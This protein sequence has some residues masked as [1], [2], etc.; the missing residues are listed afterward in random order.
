MPII[1]TDGDIARLVGEE[2][3]APANLRAKLVKLR[4]VRGHSEGK[5]DI[6]GSGGSAFRV[7]VRQ[8]DTNPLSFSVIL[9]YL[10][11]GSNVWFRLR[12]FNGSNHEHTNK[13]EESKVSFTNHI[14][15]ATERYQ[16]LGMK[17]DAYAEADP[18]FYDL[19]GAVDALIADCGFKLPQPPSQPQ[20]QPELQLFSEALDG[21]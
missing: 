9:A 13:I 11:P 19:E 1:L 16:N 8:S 21:S 7:I 3:I 14:H 4:A 2:K 10:P 6:T 18:R 17:E 20:S 5:F 15:Y 12:R